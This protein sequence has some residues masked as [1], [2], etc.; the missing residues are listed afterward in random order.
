MY[1]ITE[2]VRTNG[3]LS[4]YEINKKGNCAMSRYCGTKNIAPILDAAEKWRDRCLLQ[5]KAVFSNDDVWSLDNAQQLIKYFVE[6][7]NWGEGDFLGKLEQQLSPTTAGAKQL[8][9]E[10]MWVMLLCPSNIGPNKKRENVDAILRWAD[11]AV[12]ENNEFYSDDVLVGVGSGGTAYNNLRWKELVYFVRLIDS[13]LRLDIEKRKALLNDRNVFVRW[14]EEVEGNDNRQ[15]RHMLLFLLFPD[16]SERIF[17]ASDRLK[18]A[19]SFSNRPHKDLRKLSARE[20][21]DLLAD[22]RKEL[23]LR[24]QT[25]ELDWYVPPLNELWQRQKGAESEEIS[26]EDVLSAINEID[27]IGVDSHAQSVYYDLIYNDRPYPPK[28]VYSLA[29]KHGTGEELD[30]NAFGG[31]EGTEC[32]KVLRNLGFTINKK[33]EG[34]SEPK[35]E[36]NYDS[37]K[38]WLVAPGSGGS[39]WNEFYD[40]GLI[41]LGWNE[42]GDLRQYKS[43]EEVR[44]RL[45]EM[46][47]TGSESRVNDSLALWE[48]REKMQPGDILITKQG[49]KNYLGY[50]VVTSE[51]KYD[52]SRNGFMHIRKVD[53]K[54]KGV[55]PEESGPIVVKTLTDITKY[56]DYVER[57]RKLLGIGL[58]TEPRNIAE[59]AT[60]FSIEDATK[61]LFISPDR[62]RELL[63]LFR[64]KKNMILQGPPGV[65]KTFFA[66]RIA[67][68][69]MAEKAANRVG[70]V[71]FHQSYSYEDFIQGYRPDGTGFKLKNGIFYEFCNRA[72]SNPDQTFVFIIDEIN[73][74]NLSKVFGELMMLIEADKR[75][76]DWA[77]PL[78]YGSNLDDK[79]YVPENLYLLGLMN[80]ADR[81]LAMVDYALRRR[82][83]FVDIEPGYNTDTFRS[84]LLA[85]GAND[86]LITKIVNKMSLV[87]E[88]IRKDAT[89]LGKGYC[90]GHSFFCSI[91]AGEAADYT[92]Y[93]NIIN[94]ELAPLLREYWFDDPAQ[95]E[96]IVKD[97]L[98]AD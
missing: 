1:S 7:L 54:A 38:Y 11:I 60:P 79:F 51:Y 31:G 59:M 45:I 46:Y 6:N 97:I 34:I 63:A 14:C 22:L 9:A 40:Q 56:P 24:F 26:R 78:T 36:V 58:A 33:Q 12:P 49:Q 73:R 5:G 92:W 66:K 15:L 4:V 29:Y 21:D 87:N 37:K 67:Y 86:A 13:L 72:R 17:G 39:Y 20:L 42:V 64:K 50:G 3:Y 2:L 70:M 89:N 18:I 69:L 16:S 52:T 55:W 90:I 93:T 47:P 43:Q 57:L 44:E 30:R 62:F 85:K 48:F 88:R 53:W 68:A 61:D 71:Q 23:E 19:K 94:T 10:M 25:K 76:S 84:Y 32:F 91:P 28:L 82:F 75:G 27:E 77:M 41:G 81:S 96:S 83:A 8:A 95:A 74:G 80:T 65:G 35:T 98:L